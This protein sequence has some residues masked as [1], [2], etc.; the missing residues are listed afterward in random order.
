MLLRL[1]IAILL[2]V[3]CG[4]YPLYAV[5]NKN[6]NADSVDSKIQNQMYDFYKYWLKSK[7]KPDSVKSYGISGKYLTEFRDLAEDIKHLGMRFS[8]ISVVI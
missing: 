8:D 3:F 7:D 1:F 6:C 2:S 5:S 4:I